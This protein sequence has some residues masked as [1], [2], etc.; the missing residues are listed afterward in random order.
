MAFNPS[1]ARAVNSDRMAMSTVENDSLFGL[2]N[3]G[4]NLG[5]PESLEGG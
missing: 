5:Q 4:Q 3:R 2:K 1:Q